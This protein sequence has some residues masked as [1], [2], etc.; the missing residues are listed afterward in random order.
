M[1]QLKNNETIEALGASF[2]GVKEMI[3]NLLEKKTLL[4]ASKLL[5]RIASG[6]RNSA[7]QPRLI[8]TAS[9]L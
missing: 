9:S 7:R 2:N 4:L 1:N 3:E 5:A 8:R 6:T